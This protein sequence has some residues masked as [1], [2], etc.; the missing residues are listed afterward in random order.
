MEIC[1]KFLPRKSYDKNGLFLLMIFVSIGVVLIS[2]AGIFEAQATLECNPNKNLASDVSTRKY[3]ATQ[4]F[5]KYAKEFYP[6]LPIYAL[7][8]MNFGIV[9][10]FSIIYAHLV[11]HRVKIFTEPLSARRDDGGEE[12]LPLSTG[13]TAASADPAT[14]GKWAGRYIVFTAYVTHLIVCRII[15]LVVFAVLLLTSSS[16]PLKFQCHL[17]TK[18]TSIAPANF[19]KNSNS[20]VDCIYPMSSKN[21]ILATTVVTV[22]VVVGTVAFVELVYLLCSAWKDHNLLTDLEFCRVYLR[23][24][25]RIR[26]LKRIIAEAIPKYLLQIYDDFGGKH[27][28]IRELKDMYINVIIQEG[29]QAGMKQFENRHET[30]KAYFKKPENATTLKNTADLFIPTESTGKKIDTIYM[31]IDALFESMEFVSESTADD[32]EPAKFVLVIGR[33]GIG[34]TFLTKMMLFEWQQQKSEFWYGKIVILIRFRCFNTG[35]TSLRN[36]LQTSDGLNGINISADD[37]TAIYEYIRLYPSKVVLIFDGLDELAVDDQIGE[38]SGNG[39]NEETHI[40]NIWK[41]LVRGQLLPGVTVLTTTRPT[42]ERLYKP[43]IYNSIQYDREV[44]ILGLHE[45]EVKN[46]VEKFCGDDKQKSTEIWSLIKD[47]PELLTICYIPV[48]SYIVCLTLDESIKMNKQEEVDGQGS[49]PRTMTELYKR[50]INILLFRH[51]LEYKGKEKPKNYITAKLPK[52]LQDDL[53]KLK[54]TAR[55]G[56]REEKLIF[57]NDEVDS[58]IPDCGLFNKLEDKNQNI[59]CFL[60]LTIQ[61]FLAALDVVDDMDNVESFLSEHIEDPKW[62]LVILFVAGL[63]GDKFREMESQRYTKFVFHIF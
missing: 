61:E 22:N 38:D 35:K 44:E 28:S 26:E 39:E 46:Y 4:C 59:F 5:L 21:E 18:T 9:Y 42:A 33:P 57:Y 17:P 47:S 60:H 27:L 2:I 49:V 36:M 56:M 7:V 43:T 41:Q 16:F 20:T 19:T 58:A 1:L 30:Y 25:K 8:L 23:K 29:R 10:L 24:H 52:E 32:P 12:S 51:H 14:Y 11:E 13:N 53:N 34:K 54:E 50:A 45:E 40:Y 62:H 48:S 55:K 37:F 15:P 3:I 63:I 6:P 31:S